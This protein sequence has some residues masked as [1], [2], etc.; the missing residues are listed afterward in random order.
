MN[1]GSLKIIV[2]FLSLFI[3]SGCAKYSPRPLLVPSS[4]SQNVKENKKSINVR[5]MALSD[6]DC[7]YYF[8]RRVI[9]K[10]YQPVQLYI[11]NDS[12]RTYALDYRDINMKLENNYAVA[13]KLHLND[14]QRFVA[15][16]IP[17]LLFWPLLIPGF[18]ELV[19]VNDANN[20]LDSD[21]SNRV[22]GSYDHFVIRPHTVGNFVMFVRLENYTPELHLKLVDQD[23]FEVLNYSF[24]L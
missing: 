12:E 24:R 21:F 16:A 5:A 1:V 10:G 4:C 11:K 14:L 18:I 3:I 9:S 2:C 22:F 23:S 15:W 7:K 8:S 6:S 20:E 13:K 19:L 17:S